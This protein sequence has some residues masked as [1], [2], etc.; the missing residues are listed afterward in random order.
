MIKSG[1]LQ[2]QQRAKQR[3]SILSHTNNIMSTFYSQQKLHFFK[4]LNN[5]KLCAEVKT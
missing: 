2:L 4:T 1:L 3:M 5:Y